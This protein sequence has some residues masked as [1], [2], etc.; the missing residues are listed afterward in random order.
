MKRILIGLFTLINVLLLAQPNMDNAVISTVKINDHMHM[1]QWSGAGNM[2]LVSG[3]DGNIK[4]TN[5]DVYHKFVPIIL[6]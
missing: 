2:L 3:K 4:K 6:I 1:L 5:L